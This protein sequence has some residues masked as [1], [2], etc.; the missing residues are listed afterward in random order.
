MRDAADNAGWPERLAMLTAQDRSLGQ[1]ELAQCLARAGARGRELLAPAPDGA[2]DLGGLLRQQ[3]A[4][5]LLALDLGRCHAGW[6]QLCNRW[7]HSCTHDQAMMS[8]EATDASA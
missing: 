4:M 2:A 8:H 3:V 6:Q 1:P 5:R 7:H